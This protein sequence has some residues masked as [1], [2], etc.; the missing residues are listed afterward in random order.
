MTKIKKGE[1]F[2]QLSGFLKGKGIDLQKGSY[3]R[4]IQQG[5][6]LLTDTI[7]VS[8]DAL[9]RAKE[10]MDQGLAR[11]RQVIRAKTGQETPS[12]QTHPKPASGPGQPKRARVR[13][14][15]SAKAKS[16]KR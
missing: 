7:N 8:Q 10:E 5:C 11:M 14:R 15:T 9:H 2:G 12:G 3:T 1:L 16:R 6:K 13:R 4:R